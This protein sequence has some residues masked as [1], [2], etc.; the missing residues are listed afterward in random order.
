MPRCIGLK[1]KN[2]FCK[3]HYY[4]FL[5]HIKRLNYSG[6]IR[7]DGSLQCVVLYNALHTIHATHSM[8]AVIN[9][10]IFKQSILSCQTSNYGPV[11]MIFHS[12]KK[13][14][15]FPGDDPEASDYEIQSA[16]TYSGCC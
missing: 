4:H 8:N 15:S 14:R 2:V 12:K 3:S 7:T 9:G 10:I 6:V 16:T 5:L 1:T 13:Y 11:G